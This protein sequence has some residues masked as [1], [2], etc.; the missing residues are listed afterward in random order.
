MYIHDSADKWNRI[1][2]KAV[3]I[4]AKDCNKIKVLIDAVITTINVWK[5]TL[6]NGTFITQIIAEIGKK[7]RSPLD[8]K[9]HIFP[10]LANN[11]P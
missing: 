9:L 5:N 10:T 3:T 11:N 1:L 6:T 7:I 8:T 4:I 2:N